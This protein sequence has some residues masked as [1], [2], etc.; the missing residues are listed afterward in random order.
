MPCVLCQAPPGHHHQH[1]PP[2]CPHHLQGGRACRA[3]QGRFLSPWPEELTG[4]QCHPPSGSKAPAV[5]LG[6]QSGGPANQRPRVSPGPSVN[7]PA[8]LPGARARVPTL[9]ADEDSVLRGWSGLS[10][11]LLLASF[12]VL[13]PGTT[14][15][16]SGRAVGLTH[17]VSPPSLV[18][19]NH[20]A[21]RVCLQSCRQTPTWVAYPRQ[22]GSLETCLSGTEPAP[23]GSGWW[24]HVGPW[25]R[26]W[27]RRKTLLL[28]S[29]S[30]WPGP[31]E[32]SPVC[33]SVSTVH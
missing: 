11:R 3:S 8:P 4:P 33:L 12:Q 24:V 1:L 20:F 31:P 7:P 29:P 5:Q 15:Q 25:G 9:A 22:E 32:A 16:Y 18:H 23:R 28:A 30:S 26:G 14:Q 17:R 21:N 13:V 27:G 6:L 10:L 19:C 2:T